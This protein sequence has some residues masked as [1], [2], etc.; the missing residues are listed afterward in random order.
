M[1]TIL[2]ITPSTFYLR[3]V[4]SPNYI[5]RDQIPKC[6]KFLN[7]NQYQSYEAIQQGNS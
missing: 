4:V 1:I 7:L 3:I 6:L 5:L 2:Q